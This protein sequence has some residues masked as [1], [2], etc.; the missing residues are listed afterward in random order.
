MSCKYKGPEPDFEAYQA[1]SRSV[2]EFM[3]EEYFEY[4]FGDLWSV[5]SNVNPDMLPLSGSLFK[6]V[7]SRNN[8]R[9]RV[10][11]T[12]NISK[13][14]EGLYYIKDVRIELVKNNSL[15]S[16]DELLCIIQNY[17]FN[18]AMFRRVDIQTPEFNLAPYENTFEK[19]THI[20]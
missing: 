1:N 9:R 14:Y 18:T 2:L 15:L 12:K 6:V 16:D 10:S 4:F 11:K 20:L 5:P 19:D 7:D 17:T 8:T 13:F 3:D